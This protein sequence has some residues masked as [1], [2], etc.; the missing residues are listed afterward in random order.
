[1]VRE[2]SRTSDFIFTEVGTTG[3]LKEFE[4]TSL[5]LMLHL[6]VEISSY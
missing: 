3:Y 2:G 5:L 1:M 6:I 4:G